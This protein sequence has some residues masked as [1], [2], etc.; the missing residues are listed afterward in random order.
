MTN[1]F[2]GDPLRFGPTPPEG[3]NA[4][5]AVNVVVTLIVV[6]GWGALVCYHWRLALSALIVSLTLLFFVS[7]TRLLRRAVQW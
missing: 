7:V 3:A 4:S 1:V 2:S 6:I 5:P